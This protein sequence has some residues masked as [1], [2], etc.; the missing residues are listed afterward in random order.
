MTTRRNTQLKHA[1]TLQRNQLPTSALR[2]FRSGL[3]RAGSRELWETDPDLARLSAWF[4]ANVGVNLALGR[5]R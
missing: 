2:C 3:P 1:M 4:G 5:E